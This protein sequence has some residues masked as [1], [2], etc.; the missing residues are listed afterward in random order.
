[1]RINFDMDVRCSKCGGLI[2]GV[3][4][5]M[6]DQWCNCLPEEPKS[7]LVGWECPRCHKIHSP[8]STECDCVPLTTTET[9]YK[10]NQQ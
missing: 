3:P 9:T 4:Q 1:M 8:F 2:Y 10:T 5:Y 6:A 7:N